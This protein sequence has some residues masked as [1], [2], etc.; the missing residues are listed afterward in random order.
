MLHVPYRFLHIGVALAALLGGGAAQAD[1]ADCIGFSTDGQAQ[2]VPPEFAP[3]V[4]S[5]CIET[6]LAA[7][8]THA[9]RCMNS[10]GLSSPIQNDQQLI[11]I[12][13]CASK[14]FNP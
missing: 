14:V 13:D 9:A 4:H 12:I 10:L 7:P 2:C 5:Y 8:E 3:P 11:S 6:G 1:P